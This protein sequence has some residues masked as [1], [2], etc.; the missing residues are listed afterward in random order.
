MS[1]CSL[2]SF[3]SFLSSNFG[4]DDFEGRGSSFADFGGAS[5]SGVF[6]GAVFGET[7]NFFKVG[8]FLRGASFVGLF[9]GLFAG[10]FVGLA[11]ADLGLTALGATAGLGLT[12]FLRGGKF[13][14]R[15]KS[16]IIFKV[17]IYFFKKLTIFISIFILIKSKKYYSFIVLLKVK[18]SCQTF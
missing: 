9:L 15:G 6:G 3:L 18:K 8:N 13:L 16:D 5:F 1:R 11:T 17:T 14:K 2:R 4:R 12:T 10:L 7:G